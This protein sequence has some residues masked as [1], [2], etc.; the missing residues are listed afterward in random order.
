MNKFTIN[1][2]TDYVNQLNKKQFEAVKAVEGPVLCI[3][4]AGTGKTRTLVY[5]LAY[6]LDKGIM[7]EN[8]LLLTF[9]KKAANNMIQKAAEIIG[10]EAFRISGG[11]YHSFSALVL[12]NYAQAIGLSPDFSIADDSDS[13]D[14]IGHIR[15][16]SGYEDKEQKFPDKK[17][18]YKIFSKSSN[19][20][21]T[22][23][24]VINSS[25][26]R[27][28]ERIGEIENLF[29]E[30]S[31]Y[32]MANSIVDYDDLLIYLYKLLSEN[33]D[34][35]IKITSQYKYVMVDEYQDTNEL[36][37]KITILLSGKDSN[38]MVVGDDAQ[39]IYSFRGAKLN[40]ITDFSK[41]F[42][43]CKVVILEQNYRSTKPILDSAN[44]LINSSKAYYPKKLYSDKQNGNP[45]ALVKC[46]DE[47]QQ[48]LFIVSRIIDLYKSGIPLN[49]IAVL[50]RSAS[51]SS[52]LEVMLK[53]KGIPYVKWGGSNF[54]ETI[55]LK[56]FLAH[57]KVLC[58]PDDKMSWYRILNLL[59]GIGNV[60]S[61]KIYN[62]ISNSPEPLDLTSININKKVNASLKPLADLLNKCSC[63]YKE[64]PAK[65][66]EFVSDYY[67]PILKNRFDDYKQRIKD[68]DKFSLIAEKYETLPDFLNA[69]DI[70]DTVNATLDKNSI[71]PLVLSTIHSAKG[72][73]WN[74][75]F[76]M[77]ALHGI[78]PSFASLRDNNTYEE[79]R[80]LMYVAITRAKE[81]LTITYPSHMWDN[82]TGNLLQSPSEFIETIKETLDIWQ[83]SD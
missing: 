61:I 17:I 7:P 26:K 27:Y 45:P 29:C 47:Q 58:R 2:T 48:A 1:K 36:Q 23:E 33:E 5:R 56:D 83:I 63:Y 34:T 30:Y 22:I 10:E 54:L 68:I 82:S 24:D 11:T 44:L 77:S 52:I 35:R 70:D 15:S 6:M 81:N 32:K 38:L 79:E 69:I 67:V 50:F 37:A 65:I 3:A 51:V 8:I 73:E 72:M 75:V 74:S 25:F 78:F 62:K 18:L 20:C 57:I 4:G 64:A 53:Q 40:N 60:N 31:K 49:E 39:S 13:M 42:K 76:I 28:S 12:R 19:C 66:L 21:M 71:K 16:N 55:H 14:I 59:N 43:S 41:I 46:F 9:T 80:R